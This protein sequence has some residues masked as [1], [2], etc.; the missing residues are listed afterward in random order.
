VR[1][2]DEKDEN[3]K[4][5]GKSFSGSEKKFTAGKEKGNFPGLRSALSSKGKKETGNVSMANFEDLASDKRRDGRRCFGRVLRKKDRGKRR[6]NANVPSEKV[7]WRI[8]WGDKGDTPQTREQ[9]QGKEVDV[10]VCGCS[11]GTHERRRSG[12]LPRNRINC[13]ILSI[14]VESPGGTEGRGASRTYYPKTK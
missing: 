6:V 2:R 4:C 5:T 10:S 12:K 7:R 14:R 3:D 13:R 11:M 9:D 1:L 8:R